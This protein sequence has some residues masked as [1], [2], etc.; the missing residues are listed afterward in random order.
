MPTP[1]QYNRFPLAPPTIIILVAQWFGPLTRRGP[2]V[3]I[4]RF[5]TPNIS[6]PTASPRQVAV[7]G[8]FL[9]L[10]TACLVISKF[11]ERFLRLESK[12]E[13]YLIMRHCVDE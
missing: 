2:I 3:S 1:E 7:T 11:F 10:L 12:L 13:V 8:S 6:K 9:R 4:S 5:P